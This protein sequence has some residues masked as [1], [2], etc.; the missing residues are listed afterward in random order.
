[1]S[2]ATL[3]PIVLKIREAIIK[4]VAGKLEKYGFDENGTLAIVKPLSEYDETIRD[5]LIALFEAKQINSQEKYVDY[6]HN[7]SRTF[8]HIL[9]S[10]KLMEKRGIMGT[11]L[12]RVVGTNIYNEIIPNYVNINPMAFD[13]FVSKF[14]KEIMN[15]ASKDNGEEDDEYY[16]FNYLMEVLT[17]EMSQ[18][19]PLLFKEYEFNLIQPDYDDLRVILQAVSTIETEEYDEDDFLGWIY[20]YWVDTDSSDLI[21]SEDEKDISYANFIYF[22]VLILLDLEQTEFGEFYTPRWVVKY[23]VDNS[24]QYYKGNNDI[25][26]EK[27]KLLDPACGAGNFL[28]YAFDAILK[29]YDTEHPDWNIK[30]KVLS[31]LENNIFGADIQREPLQITALN[32]WIKAKTYAVNTKINTMNLFNVNVLMANSLYPWETEEEFHQISLF[33]TPDTIIEKKYS[34][35]DIGRLLSSRNQENHNSA[36]RFF[37]QKFDI[38]V[39]N[40]PFV[41][42]RNM[43][44]AT[45]DFMKKYYPKNSRNLVAAFIDRSLSI[46]SDS[47]IIGFIASDTF[48]TL[49]SYKNL[50][51]MLLDRVSIRKM[52]ELGFGVFEADVSCGMYFLDKKYLKRNEISYID[53]RKI[54]KKSENSI[55]QLI[56]IETNAETIKQK[57]FYEYQDY[58][59][60]T[61]LPQS[62]RKLYSEK[63]CLGLGEKPIAECRVGI[64][65]GDNED[66]FVTKKWMIPDRFLRE[67]KFV[68]ISKTNP[69]SF[70]RDY[71]DAVYWEYDGSGIKDNPGCLWQ[72]SEF[73][74]K[75]G[76]S[77]NL[78][79]RIFKVRKIQEEVLFTQG[80]SGIFFSEEYKQYED[81]F[82]GILKSKVVNY[83]L[84]KINPTNNTTPNDVKKIPMI[85]GSE[86]QV[87]KIT[88]LSIK[89]QNSIINRKK[90]ESTSDYYK[91]NALMA[92]WNKNF[93]ISAQ[94]YIRF[95]ETQ[96][97]DEYESRIDLDNAVYDLFDIKTD[98]KERIEEEFGSYCINERS[99]NSE[100]GKCIVDLYLCGRKSES[101]RQIAPL[102]VI[103]ISEF[104]D[105]KPRQILEY[106][107][108]NGIFR[109]TEIQSVLVDFLRHISKNIIKENDPAL[110]V[111]D[112][113][114][115]KVIKKIEENYSNGVE[116]VEEIE[117]ILGVSVLD[118][119][120]NGIK[121]GTIKTGIVASDEPFLEEVILGGKGKNKE[122]VVWY[123]PHFLIEYEEDK[124]YSMQN[125][126]RRLLNEV[127]LPKLQRSKEK[128]QVEISVALE[129]KNLEK[130]VALYE[131][132]VKT[133]E[134]W[135]VVE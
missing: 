33:E 135:K 45:K 110:Y 133:L 98:E 78:G 114:A 108:E 18:E 91:E 12:E 36:V 54:D 66:Q 34:S 95:Y 62:L 134:N 48:K 76:L 10:F 107:A 49:V 126:I 42:T 70:I 21:S 84:I 77:Y 129:Q 85:I 118:L 125:E 75:K 51:K 112:E 130:E 121:L 43:P 1:M 106:C 57:I 35:E 119:F 120:L 58:V 26:V 109:D 2:R 32:L 90:Y 53:A 104:L 67:K 13:E 81:Y 56:N 52:I 38:I 60:L 117:K 39:M 123:T 19:V 50:R 102:S 47:S 101:G 115:K 94:N 30:E 6:I 7:T 124:R 116:L 27:I 40:P 5:N 65:I 29:L 63:K 87:K 17:R 23:I 83:F 37:K 25:P 122:S 88:E 96:E 132:C 89:I 55:M 93:M 16:Q 97:V 113:L 46:T 86:Q 9:I 8:M 111:I 82:L 74:F 92:F 11:L 80:S 59:F 20:Q 14:E 68:L 22:K 44:Q 100:T 131:E 71:Q 3:K 105:I 4:G 69:E 15:L 24:I 73:Y 64:K 41:D 31:V 28:V 72:N 103:E 79:G 128:L 61:D 99:I 127:Y